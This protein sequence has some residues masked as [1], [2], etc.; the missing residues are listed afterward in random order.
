MNNALR[1][2]LF[3]LISCSVIILLFGTVSASALPIVSVLP[4]K[5]MDSGNHLDWDGSTIYQASFDS[6]VSVWNSYKPE[7]IREDS[8]FTWEDVYISDIYEVSNMAG[9]T[10]SSGSI[11]FNTYQMGSLTY[12]KRLNTCIHELGHALGL[13]HNTSTDV[14]YEKVTSITSLS[15]NDKA[16]F[17]YSYTH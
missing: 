3:T 10:Y 1:K 16:S 4:W 11:V 12:E 15:D 14:M 8:M 6:A 17:D 9:R 2:K 5:L 13:D 7:V